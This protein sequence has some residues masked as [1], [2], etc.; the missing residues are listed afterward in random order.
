MREFFK[1]WILFIMTGVI[2]AC[3]VSYSF[4]GG[5]VPAE[6]ETFSVQDVP[7]R[8]SIVNPML[9]QQFKDGLIDRVESRTKLR[10]VNGIGQGDFQAEITR[11]ETSPLG[12]TGNETAAQNR[13]TIAIKVKY[14][15]EIDP[16]SNFDRSFSRY[17]DYSSG[18]NFDAVEQELVDEIIE[19]ILDD[20]FNAAFVNW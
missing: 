12:I 5:S 20:I 15:N 8:A 3:S 7:N 4:T 16:D 19:L 6:M 10:S 9:S 18:Q 1:I 13:L 2:C 11:Y 14:V 17:A